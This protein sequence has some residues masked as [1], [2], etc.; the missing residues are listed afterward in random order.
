[1]W[2]NVRVQRRAEIMADKMPKWLRVRCNEMFGGGIWLTE[3]LGKLRIQLF[4]FVFLPFLSDRVL[5]HNNI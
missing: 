3:F 4:N 5:R 1:M 2:P